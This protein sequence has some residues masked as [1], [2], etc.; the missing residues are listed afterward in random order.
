VG[1]GRENPAMKAGREGRLYSATIR[2][3][4]TPPDGLADG[5][6]SRQT[7]GISGNTDHHA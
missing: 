1:L 6:R 2:E 7:L 5:P 4:G 3:L